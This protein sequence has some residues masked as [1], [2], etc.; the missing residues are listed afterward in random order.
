MVLRTGI[1]IAAVA[2][3]LIG[4]AAPAARAADP[5]RWTLTGRSTLPLEYYQG[6]AGDGPTRPNLFFNGI[7][8]GLYRTDPALKETARNADVIP[9]EVKATEGWD[10]VGDIAYDRR[11]GGRVL[12]PVECYYPNA[13]PG[14]PDPNNTCRTGAFA[15]ADPATLRWRYYVKLD[16]AEIPKA[17][18]VAVSPDGRLL[19]TQSGV[20]LLA[21]RA[22]DV[23]PSNAGPGG[24]VI[25]AVRRLRNARPPSGIT[26]AAFRDG[27]L[28]VAGQ[29]NPIGFQVWSIDVTSGERRLEFERAVVGE[30]EGIEFFDGLGG[31]LHW[32]VAPYNTRTLP[33][34]GPFYT[35]T[36]LHLAPRATPGSPAPPAPVGGPQRVARI[37]VAVSPRRAFAG[38]RTRFAFRLTALVAGR[39]RAVAG[40]TVRMAGRTVRTNRLGRAV[41]WRRLPAGRYGVRASRRDLSAGAASVRVVPPPRRR[42]PAEDG[43]GA[44]A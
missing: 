44:G 15:V 13:A 11:E 35:S 30:S 32:I 27:R 36:L 6:V 10:H 34:E 28:Y 26:G 33:S 29:D 14:Q 39:R 24:P 38:R 17:M 43:D 25:K 21:Y 22:D 4:A 9:P 23:R 41:M 3:T 18:W 12:L 31:A 2:V 5:G 19:W 20:D 8:S 40:A 7:E 1:R 37:H 16:P 42:A